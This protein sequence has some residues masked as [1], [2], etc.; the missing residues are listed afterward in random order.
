[1]GYTLEYDALN[2]LANEFDRLD[3]NLKSNI[4]KVA[5]EIGNDL[6]RNT[7]MAIP[8]EK[9]PRHELHLAD[10]VKLN[11]KVTDKA[12]KITVKGGSKTGGYWWIVDNGHVA[13]DGTFVPGAHFTDKAYQAT[14]V[15]E[16]V[17]AM[18]NE[19]TNE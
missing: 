7:E 14:S 19:V 18:I 9:K 6:K 11:V 4:E 5:N 16:K 13:K 8:K 3:A 1:M 2:E 10:D 17:D 12:A 15:S